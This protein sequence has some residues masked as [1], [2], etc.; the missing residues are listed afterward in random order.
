[1]DGRAVGKGNEK[2]YEEECEKRGIRGMREDI[3]KVMDRGKCDRRELLDSGEENERR[4]S[5][6]QILRKI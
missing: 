2:E 3:R 1:M 4:L 5:R 6:K